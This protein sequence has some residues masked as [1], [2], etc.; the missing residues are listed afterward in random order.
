[1][2]VIFPGSFDPF[3]RGH[4]DIVRRAL[5]IFDKVVIAIGH[6]IYKKSLLTT[7]SKICLIQDIFRDEP[8]VEVISYEGLTVDLCRKMNINNVLR[9]VRSLPDFELECSLDGINRMLHSEIETII[10]LTDPHYA[11]VSSTAVREIHLYGGSLEKFM[12][13]GIELEKYI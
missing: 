2:A 1:M 11:F 10:L 8:R 3:T 12:S 13:K 6:N 4:E 9:G 7:E 5:M